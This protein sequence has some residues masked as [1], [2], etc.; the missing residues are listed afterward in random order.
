MTKGITKEVHINTWKQAIIIS[1]GIII[2]Y[3]Y[4]HLM[5]L[6][7]GRECITDA[8]SVIVIFLGSATLI[9]MS[10]ISMNSKVLTSQIF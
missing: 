10:E 7:K 2:M 5:R 4:K 6:I 1:G 9:Y 3:L 8:E